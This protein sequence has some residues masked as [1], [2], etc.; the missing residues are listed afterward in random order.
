MQKLSQEEKAD[1]LE[2]LITD[3]ENTLTATGE[4]AMI[5]MKLGYKTGYQMSIGEN[6]QW[7]NCTRDT[8]L[9]AMQAYLKG[10]FD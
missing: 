8:L 6:K 4:K 10:E 9:E 3:T 2:L 7:S 1:L 5:T